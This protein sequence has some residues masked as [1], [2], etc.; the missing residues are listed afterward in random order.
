V[1]GTPPDIVV[2]H[3][4]SWAHVTATDEVDAWGPAA[5]EELWRR[6]RQPY[7]RTDVDRLAAKLR[8]LGAAVQR[9]GSYGAFFLCPELAR[10]P[11]ATVR[12]NG[13]TYPSGTDLQQVID[14]FLFPVELQLLEPEVHHVAGSHLPHV[15]IRQRAY[16]DETRSLSD[17]V[18]YVF[19]FDD[20]ALVLSVSFLDPLQSAQWLPELD[21]LAGGVQLQEAAE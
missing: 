19:P 3:S 16:T 9:S 14:D 2:D 15:R 21:V 13:L 11:M 20:A 7:S 1:T 12:L 8:L 6:S 4:A 17:H 18:A 5:A 10:G